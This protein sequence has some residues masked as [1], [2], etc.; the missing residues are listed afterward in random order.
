MS[1]SAASS[2][3]ETTEISATFKDLMALKNYRYLL[4]GQFVSSL[5]DGVYLLAVIWTMKLLTGSALQ[6]SFVLA[7]EVVP[8]IVLGLIA[9]VFVDQGNQKKFMLLSDFF[10][11]AAVV[12][13]V[14]LYTFDLLAPWMLIVTAVIIS[15]FEAFFSPAKAVAIKTIIP[16]PLLTRA[17]SLSSSIDTI[18]GLTAPVLAALLL[19]YSVTAAFVFNAVSYIASFVFIALI[20]EKK[21]SQKRTEPLQL[22]GFFTQLKGGMK[23]IATISILRNLILYISAINFALAPI[24]ILIPLIVNNP[25]QLATLEVVFFIGLLLGSLSIN[26]LTKIRKIILIS[27][28]LVIIGCGLGSLALPFGFLVK[29]VCMGVVGVGLALC[30]IPLQSLFL[31]EVPQEVAGR[32]SSTMSVIVQSCKPLSLLLTGSILAIVSIKIFLLL[33]GL[34]ILATVGLMTMNTQLRS[35]K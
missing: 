26:F 19:A 22:P 4:L 14:V 21:L 20:S 35:A 9:G 7:A 10:R 13:I 31:T 24:A 18:I 3:I 6:M 16:K 27:C 1:D 28:G 11:G 29:S 32:A 30:N 23:T 15:S 12:A 34:F 8:L 33:I 17:Q 25:S 2:P 5:G